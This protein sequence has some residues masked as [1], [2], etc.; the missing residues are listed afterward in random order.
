MSGVNE[1]SGIDDILDATTGP[2]GDFAA[3][4]TAGLGGASYAALAAQIVAQTLGTAPAVPEGPE[5]P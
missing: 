2:L 4:L 1:P 5:T 3:N